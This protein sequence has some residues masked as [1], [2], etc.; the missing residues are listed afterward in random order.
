VIT[1]PRQRN[2]QIKF[3]LS[4]DEASKLHDLVEKSKLKQSD[5]VRKCILQKNIIVIEG[6]REFTIE[7]NRIGTN[8]NQITKAINSY[9]IT[10]CKNEIE[11]MQE[12]VRALW[13][14]LNVYLRSVK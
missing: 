14:S 2:T 13:Q 6:L 8:L 9:Q 1:V 4:K 11:A 3:W 12:E 10:D 7:L 5:Y